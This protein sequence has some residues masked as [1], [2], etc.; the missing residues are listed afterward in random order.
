MQFVSFYNMG[1]FSII[2]ATILLLSSCNSSEITERYNNGQKKEEK[3]YIKSKSDYT[4]IRYFQNGQKSFEGK[5]ENNLFVNK[6][7]SYFENGQI[8][9]VDSLFKPCI[10]NFCCCDGLVTRFREN[11]IIEET[12]T[13][14]NGVENGIVRVYDTLG[15]LEFEYMMRKGKKN[16]LFKTYFVNGNISFKATFKNDTIIGYALYLKENGDTL[17]MMKYNGEQ[18]DFPYFKWLENGQILK[19]EL[20]NNGRQALWSWMDKNRKI[21]KKEVVNF[22]KEVVAPE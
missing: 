14:I 11:G 19:G 5:I 4:L 17:K 15:K 8:S 9:Q 1:N 10:L 22:D 16:G 20:T 3:V 6:K 7:T 21:I 12:F 2:V 13:N 18:M